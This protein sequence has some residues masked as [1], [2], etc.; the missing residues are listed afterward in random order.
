M[1]TL[2]FI[3]SVENGR[4]VLETAARQLTPV[5]LEP[6]R[7]GSV[8]R[9][10]RRRSRSRRAWLWPPVRSSTAAQNCVAAERIL[11]QRSIA[12]RF[13]EKVAELGA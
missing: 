2:V 8:H 13:E 5:V 7:Q 4:K 9:V 1:D 10:R 11:V 12:P 3:G 6:R